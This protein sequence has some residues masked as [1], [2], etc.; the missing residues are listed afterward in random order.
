MD[1]QK[2]ILR[3]ENFIP[4]SISLLTLYKDIIYNK[5]SKKLT[6]IGT[7][8]K[9][10]GTYKYNLDMNEEG[11]SIRVN[12]EMLDLL[13][14]EILKLKILSE[15]NEIQIEQSL[16]FFE[17]KLTDMINAKGNNNK[18][19][20]LEYDLAILVNSTDQLVSWFE[21][22]GLNP[23]DNVEKYNEIKKEIPAP[24]PPK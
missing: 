24:L 19:K 17:L 1:E 21:E 15:F 20:P 22:E 7:L 18:I 5:K 3:T 12:L 9:R 11:Q 2:F 23:P 10:R 16:E 8:L 4:R 6:I 13:E 14:D